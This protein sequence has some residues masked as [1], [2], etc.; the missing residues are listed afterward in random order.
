MSVYSPSFIRQQLGAVSHIQLASEVLNC[1]DQAQFFYNTPDYTLISE[2]VHAQ[3]Q[4]PLQPDTAQLQDWLNQ[5]KSQLQ[6]VIKQGHV[7]AKIMGGLPFSTEQDAPELLISDSRWIQKLFFQPQKSSDNRLKHYR[8]HPEAAAYQAGVQALV[9]EMQQ[10]QLNKAVL[11]RLVELE[12][13]QLINIS[14]VFQS[15][16]QDNPDGYNYAIASHPQQHGWF[17][18]ASP[19]LLIA[20]QQAQVWSQPVAGTLARSLDAV[21]DQDNARQ[22]FNS[23]KDQLEHKVVI[24]MIADQLNPFCKQLHIPKQPSL[25][26]TRRLWH[27]A[28]QIQGELKHPDTHV[29][30]LVEVLHPTPAVCGQPPQQARQ[31]IRELEPFQRELF[32]GAMGWADGKGNGAWSVTVR[33][34]RIYQNFARLF[35]G[36]GIVAQSDPQLEHAETAAKFRTVLDGLGLDSQR[37]QP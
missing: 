21:T 19:E 12:F 32:A 17:I 35:A 30:D 37:L 28:T 11:A 5:A 18:G 23:E 31:R 4:A 6:E 20:K 22:L 8:Y 27:L 3:V 25:I 13:E 9:N 16:V 7:D 26:R 2:K 33:C 29:F 36:A 34:A 10:A 15:L 14:D 24:E 1:R